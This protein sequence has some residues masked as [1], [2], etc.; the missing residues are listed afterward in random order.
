MVLLFE[1][2]QNNLDRSFVNE[3]VFVINSI[4]FVNMRGVHKLNKQIYSSTLR[5]TWILI[6]IL[7]GFQNKISNA[8]IARRTRNINTY[9][10]YLHSKFRPYFQ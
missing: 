5:F 2:L 4:C 6:F 7:E 10:R 8:Y 1:S 3:F 9:V